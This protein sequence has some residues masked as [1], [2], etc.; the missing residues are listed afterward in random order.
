[1]PRV[2]GRIGIDPAVFV[3]TNTNDAGA[4]SLRQAILDA[5][6]AGE[7]STIAFAIDTG[8]QRIRPLADLQHLGA[9]VAR[10]Q[11]DAH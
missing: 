11:D 8:H 4:G 10:D 2:N 5:G 7:L 9:A 1:M 6:A 3:V